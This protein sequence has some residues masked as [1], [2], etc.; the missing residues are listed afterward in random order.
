MTEFEDMWD[1]Q[2]GFQALMGEDALPEADRI[3]RLGE[4]ALLAT[5][6]GVDMLNALGYKHHRP[7]VKPNWANARAEYVDMLKYTLAIGVVSG[8]NVQAVVSDFWSKSDVVKQRYLRERNEDRSQPCAIFD[9]DGVIAHYNAP[10]AEEIADGAFLRAEPYL[11]TRALLG[12]VQAAGLRV[13]IITARKETRYRNVVTDT[14]RWLK[15]H[16][17]PYD[18]LIFA[19]DKRTAA[20][21]FAPVFA[22]EDSPKHAMDYASAGIRTWLITPSAALM[23]PTPNLT[24]RY[25]VSE[26]VSDIETLLAGR[27]A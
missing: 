25:S 15:M 23:P 14:E 18:S 11:T 1:E 22:V 2:K 5:G 17:V 6:E 13:V 3:A 7:F 19:F 21:D 26:A 4:L 24:I 20:E 16:A 8:F 27:T 10:S 12:K 9:L